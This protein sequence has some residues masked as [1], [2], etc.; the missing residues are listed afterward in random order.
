MPDVNTDPFASATLINDPQFSQIVPEDGAG[1]TPEGGTPQGPPKTRTVDDEGFTVLG[2]ESATQDG[3]GAN[4]EGGQEPGLPE[5]IAALQ[6][7]ALVQGEGAEGEDGE[8]VLDEIT[9]EDEA[10]IQGAP[11]EQEYKARLQQ[12]K[13]RIHDVNSARIGRFKAEQRQRD[14]ETK[15]IQRLI[16]EGRLPESAA[17]VPR[18]QEPP[19][20]AQQPARRFATADPKQL[21]EYAAMVQ[22]KAARDSSADDPSKYVELDDAY[23]AAKEAYLE[24]KF[25]MKF[26]ANRS[27]VERAKTV[28]K[29]Y[30]TDRRLDQEWTGD[31]VRPIPWADSQDGKIPGVKSLFRILVQR[32]PSLPSR[33]PHTD[34]VDRA[35]WMATVVSENFPRQHAI[36][37]ERVRATLM[38]QKTAK[39][40]A[41]PVVSGQTSPLKAQQT[42]GD[43]TSGY[44]AYINQGRS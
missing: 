36:H 15:A 14:A 42:K 25:E 35:K 26:A 8:L 32:D 27:E 34:P 23:E 17:D 24:A 7:P 18:G 44:L 29:A 3:E 41:A 21:P 19:P 38:K 13:K 16:A 30:E 9:A 4:G 10:F 6:E 11:D 33:N 12:V 20:P 5:Y 37:I 40:A 39:T 22:A 1:A 2:R 43:V 28:E 31:L